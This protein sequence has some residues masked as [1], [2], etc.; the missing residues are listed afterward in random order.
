MTFIHLFMTMY[1]CINP[2]STEILGLI[3]VVGLIKTWCKSRHTHMHIPFGPAKTGHCSYCDQL[4]GKCTSHLPQQS[5]WSTGKRPQNKHQ[6]TLKGFLIILALPSGTPNSQVSN[7]GTLERKK[8][9]L[10]PPTKYIFFCRCIHDDSWI[11]VTTGK[12]FRGN[13]KHLK[14]WRKEISA[15]A[16][17]HAV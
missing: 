2:E 15:T 17:V 9:L 11:E 1:Q 13:S 8:N 14:V 5:V 16:K 12:R 10:Q 3:K 4:F 6:R 7:G